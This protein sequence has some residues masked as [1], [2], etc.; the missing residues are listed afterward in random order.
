MTTDASPSTVLARSVPADAQFGFW[1]ALG[2]GA[3]TLV[4]F[5]MAIATPPLSGPMCQEGCLT[6]P[7]IDIAARFPR[8]YLWMFPAMVA[9]LLSM[10]FLLAIQARARPERRLMGQLGV[11]LSVMAGLTILGDY[12]LQLA[13]I[14][15]SVLAGETDG[16]SVLTQYNPHGIFI[17]LEELGYLLM[18]AS[19]A[20]MAPTLSKATRL[21]RTV[22]RIFIG[23][24]IASL[25]ALAWFAIAYGHRRAYLFELAVISIVWLTLIPSAFMMA[26]VFRRS[27]RGSGAVIVRP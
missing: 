22:G 7:Y 25:A 3:V 14:Q 8:D 10:A 16:V 9:T 11:V 19:L 1:A 21:E 20:C 2:T 13:V 12:F 5:G 24:L 26:A 18:S 23:G 15:P 6:Y 17:A 27:T 4:T